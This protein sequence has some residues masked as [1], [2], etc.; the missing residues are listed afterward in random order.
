MEKEKLFDFMD[1]NNNYGFMVDAKKYTK[2]QAIEAA[3][4]ELG[5]EDKAT[6]E[7]SAEIEYIRYTVN[8][9]EEFDYEPVYIT[10]EKSD[11]GAFPAWRVLWTG[12]G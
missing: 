9:G 3:K 10:C 4:C 8:G 6:S 1:F 2:E 7:F 11:R 12:V 5:L